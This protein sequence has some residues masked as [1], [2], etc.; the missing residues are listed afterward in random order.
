MGSSM[1]VRVGAV[2]KMGNFNIGSDVV[3]NVFGCQNC[4]KERSGSFCNECGNKNTTFEKTEKVYIK[5]PQQ[6]IWAMVS[7]DEFDGNED[8]FYTPEY[9]NNAVIPNFSTQFSREFDRYDETSVWEIPDIESQKIAISEIEEHEDYKI[10][11][12]FCEKHN[13]ECDVI[14]GVITYWS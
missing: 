13:I 2:V 12:K 10:L 11:K 8:S 9:C 14:Y 5:E 1:F 4:D 6:L 7:E 3:K